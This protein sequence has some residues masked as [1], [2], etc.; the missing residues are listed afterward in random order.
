[1]EPVDE[2]SHSTFFCE[3]SFSI[4]HGLTTAKMQNEKTAEGRVA[5]LVEGS[6]GKVRKGKTI[7]EWVSLSE[8]LNSR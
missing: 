1:M 3:Q 4:S 5:V 2:N 8:M 6:D 7:P